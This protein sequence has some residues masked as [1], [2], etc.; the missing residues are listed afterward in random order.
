MAFA[1]SP[2]PSTNSFFLHSFFL[3]SFFFHSFFF[4]FFF[5]FLPL[6]SCD[7]DPRIGWGSPSLRLQARI[8]SSS[9]PSSSIP[10]SSIPSSSSSLC[11]CVILIPELDGVR[12]LS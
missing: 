12:L 3:H 10:S 6:Q 1:F 9:I 4:H 7:P 2:P 8:P 11:S 5:F